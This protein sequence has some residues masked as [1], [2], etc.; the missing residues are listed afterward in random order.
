MIL[1]IFIKRKRF[2]E[3]F[4]VFEIVKGIDKQNTII[5]LASN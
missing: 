1:P 3:I 4:D 5:A 2:F